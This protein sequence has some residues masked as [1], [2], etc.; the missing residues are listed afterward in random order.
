M[1]RSSSAIACDLQALTDAERKREQILLEMFRSLLVDGTWN[2]N[3]VRFKI[4]ADAT[5]LSQ[6]GEFIAYERRC[7]PFLEWQLAVDS[8]DRASLTI[9]GPEGT[10]A[11]VE[12][13]FTR[14]AD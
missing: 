6:V 4:P 8:T 1:N 10:R 2:G 3:E 14:T 13:T 9:S 5:M 12:A 7:C 11:F